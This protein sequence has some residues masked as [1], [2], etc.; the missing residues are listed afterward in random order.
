MSSEEP[1]R[2]PSS[3]PGVLVFASL[4][5]FNA[6]C[7][8]AGLAAGW[9][10]DTALHTLPL[11]MMVGLLVGIGLGVVGTRNYLRRYL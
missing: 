4:G 11:C 10:V 3:G 7:M 1:G 5:M 9:A 8:L 2:E 6:F